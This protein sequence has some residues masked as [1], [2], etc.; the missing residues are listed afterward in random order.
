MSKSDAR[1]KREIAPFSYGL[2]EVN[3]IKPVWFRYNGLAET[4]AGELHAG[5]IA[6]ELEV[7]AP[8]LVE[9][10]AIRLRPQDEKP[11]SIRKVN[12]SRIDFALIRAV[13]EQ[14]AQLDEL[15]GRLCREQGHCL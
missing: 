8:R 7:V 11:T 5:V 4:T 13:Q 3:S 12:Y 14:Q 6:Q 15:K 9:T 1:L 2:K 10:E